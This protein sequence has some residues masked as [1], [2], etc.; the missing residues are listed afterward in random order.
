MYWFAMFVNN[1]RMNYLSTY[2]RPPLLSLAT[3]PK[4]FGVKST[5][6]NMCFIKMLSWYRYLVRFDYKLLKKYSNSFDETALIYAYF[7]DGPIIFKTI[8][9]VVS[10]YCVWAERPSK[11][12]L[13]L[14]WQL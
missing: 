5:T 8:N 4:R 12:A 6:F 1:L 2:L 13:S 10:L 7:G 3:C 14:D 11:A 9:Y